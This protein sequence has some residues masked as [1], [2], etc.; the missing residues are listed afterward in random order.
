MQRPDESGYTVWEASILDEMEHGH[1][2][3]AVGSVTGKINISPLLLL[4]VLEKAKL[5]KGQKFVEGQNVSFRCAT[6]TPSQTEYV[7]RTRTHTGHT[8]LRGL[9]LKE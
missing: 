6:T 4:L 7:S 5:A 3:A 9:W 8:K 2:T 1:A